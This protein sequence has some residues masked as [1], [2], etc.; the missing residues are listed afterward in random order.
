MKSPAIRKLRQK[1]ASH[2]PAVGLWVT[3]ESPSITEMAVALGV[4]WVVI[5]AE[6]GHLDWNDILNHI[7]ATVRSDTVAL[8]RVSEANIGLIKRALDIGADGVVVPWIESVD[9]LREAVR[10][11]HYPPEGLRGIGAERATCWGR[12]FTQAVNEA[13]E[14]VLVIPIIETV[15]AGKNID[16]ICGVEGVE[17]LWL[18]P[19]DYSSTAGFPGQ[20]EGPGVADQLLRVKDVIRAHGKHAGVIATSNDNLTQRSMQGFAMLGL[21]MDGGLLLRSLSGALATVGRDRPINPTFTLEGQTPAAILDRPPDSF[22]PDRPE[23]MNAPGSGKKIELERGVNFE[24]LVGAHN[25]A[26]NLT[27]GIVT[28]SPGASLPYHTHPFT[29]S[30]TLLSGSM[31]VEVE[32]RR[33]TL[34]PMDNVV[35]PRE[36]A[37]H[38]LNPSRDEQAVLHI[39]MGSSTPTRAMTEKFFSKKAMPDDSTGIPGTERVNRFATA[40][41]F[42]AAPNASFI[43]FFNNTLM[44]DAD[45]EM[46]G[47]YGLFQPTGRLPAHIHDF[48]ESICIVQGVATCVV[49]GRR[50]SQTNLSTALQ[51]RGRV[52]YFIN[53]SN[54]PMAMLWVYAG[55]KPERIVVD[56]KNGTVEGNP[57]K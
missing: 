56:E 10:F 41:R 3:L 8:V 18:G 7:R 24:C 38:A 47:G 1:L 54:A 14:H 52:H 35:I 39:A 11:A 20:W 44:P 57:W 32:G 6:H 25:N 27:T 22:R 9:Q 53:E 40:K 23:S 42:D 31:V 19:A 45:I 28:F 21:G 29:E 26:R 43:D 46:S 50:Y 17:I 5:D 34:K 13:D 36:R 2:A 30:I 12:C 16:A 55:P 4:D 48:D 37:H 15:R 49:E 51:P 33:Y